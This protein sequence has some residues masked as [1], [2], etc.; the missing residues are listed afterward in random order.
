M[1][2]PLITSPPPPDCF[3]NKPVGSSVKPCDVH[4]IRVSLVRQPDL[5]ARPKWWAPA[6]PLPY[7]SEPYNADTPQGKKSGSLDGQGSVRFDGIPAGTCQFQ[8]KKFYE[9]IE[10]H[11]KETLGG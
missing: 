2:L 3:D 9:K 7:A 5:K 8:F 11:F 4:W 10:Q 1:C 6:K